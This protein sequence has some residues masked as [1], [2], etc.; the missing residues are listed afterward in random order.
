MG[1]DRSGSRLTGIGISEPRTW[2]DDESGCYDVGGARL[3]GVPFSSPIAGI[4]ALTAPSE[5]DFALEASGPQSTNFDAISNRQGLPAPDSAG[6]IRQAVG[7]QLMGCDLPNVVT[8]YEPMYGASRGPSHLCR[9]WDLSI[10]LVYSVASGGFWDITYRRRDPDT[11]LWTAEV[12]I[13]SWGSP[14]FPCLLEIP[15]ERGYRLVCFFWGDSNIRAYISDDLGA[16]WSPTADVLEQALSVTTYPVATRGRIRAGWSD[17]QIL[18]CAVA[19]NNLTGNR[20][21]LQFA[22]SDGAALFQRVDT[23]LATSVDIAVFDSSFVVAITDTN[24]IPIVYIAGDAWA[25]LS[26]LV[27]VT[28]FAPAPAFVSL[29]SLAVWTDDDGALYLIAYDS[30]VTG[31]TSVIRSLDGVTWNATGSTLTFVGVTPSTQPIWYGHAAASTIVVDSAIHHKGGSYFTFDIFNA[32]VRGQN[33]HIARLGGWNGETKPTDTGSLS[34]T[35]R[36]CWEHS[37][38]CDRT[39]LTWYWNGGV[40]AGETM[41]I[42]YITADGSA[43]GG[44]YADTLALAGSVTQGVEQEFDIE[45]APVAGGCIMETRCGQ[46]GGGGGSWEVWVYLTQT[47]ARAWDPN[48]GGGAGAWLGAAVTIAGRQRIRICIA[49]D[50]TTGL[51][52]CR[53]IAAPSNP[54]SD[55]DR[56]WTVVATSAALAA[57]AAAAHRLRLTIS[58]GVLPANPVRW[59]WHGAQSSSQTGSQ[60]LTAPVRSTLYPRNVLDTGVWFGHGTYLLAKSGPT[61]P[62]ET[63]RVSRSWEYGPDNLDPLGYVPSVRAGCK[64]A[65][66]DLP[67]G[68]V[69]IRMAWR[70]AT[71][72][73]RQE[74]DLWHTH[75]EALLSW[76]VG[77]YV[78]TGGAWVPISTTPTDYHSIALSGFR[79]RANGTLDSGYRWA[80]NELSSCG[81]GLY[82]AA[83]AFLSLAK[84]LRSTG[85]CS[86]VGSYLQTLTLDRYPAAGARIRVWPRRM[87]LIRRLSAGSTSISSIQIRIPVGAAYQPVDGYYGLGALS[88]GPVVVLGWR[89]SFL[90]PISLDSGRSLATAEDKTRT[91]TVTGPSAHTWQ[92][93]FPDPVPAYDPILEP[94]PDYV[95]SGTGGES[96]AYRQGAASIVELMADIGQAYPVVVLP[97]CPRP[98][99]HSWLLDGQQALYAWPISATIT[100]DS[101]FGE[102]DATQGQALAGRIDGWTFE[103]A[104]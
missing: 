76:G 65:V 73:S 103:E 81:C 61:Y 33:L 50:L 85:G 22:S 30:G 4:P 64:I 86:A 5:S 70:V 16:T 15:T 49:G 71:A 11:G 34:P 20:E 52:T 44:S 79:A 17:G 8:G 57:G 72:D 38:F 51:G 56:T 9:L 100:L 58:A 28:P 89:S 101:Q 69:E 29:S 75:L 88:V 87:T 40:G 2:W 19:R 3:S 53:V 48:A 94:D 6:L 42:G 104:V 25:R 39:P 13:A 74:S 66:A 102:E 46:A 21:L 67:V 80:R 1:V 35:G 63:W 96:V 23:I 37:H 54:I 31:A 18:L 68:T 95:S 36:T 27:G 77:I 93:Q 32:A 97:S 26:T 90:R 98:A 62:G 92:L 82:T 83:D 91:S 14:P 7:G 55:D 78:R 43:G 24:Y 10:G 41:M 99:T 84:V 12:T 45:G 47:T 59:Y 60:G